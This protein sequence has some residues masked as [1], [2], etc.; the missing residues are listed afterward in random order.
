MAS[1]AQDSEMAFGDLFKVMKVIVGQ[2]GHKAWDPLS[3]W[4][5]REKCF[6]GLYL[7]IGSTPISKPFQNTNFDILKLNH[8]HRWEPHP[9]EKF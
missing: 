7:A 8:T 4:S 9:L 5:V 2:K 6:R 3:E 1:N